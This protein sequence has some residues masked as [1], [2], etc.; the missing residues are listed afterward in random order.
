MKLSYKLFS[1]LF[2][3]SLCIPQV[4]AQEE[5]V[6]ANSQ[7]KTSNS[8]LKAY[9]SSVLLKLPFYEDFAQ[10][11]KIP[12]NLLWA[13]FDVYVNNSYAELPPS[14]GMASFDAINDFGEIYSNAG[15]FS[16]DADMLTSRPINLLEYQP[17]YLSSYIKGY[18]ETTSQYFL[19]NDIAYLKDGESFTSLK[20]LVFWYTSDMTLYIKVG[21]GFEIY[22]ADVF[23]QNNSLIEKGTETSAFYKDYSVDDEVNISFYYQAGGVFGSLGKNSNVPD[24]NDILQLE[25]SVPYDTTGVFINEITEG[26]IEIYNATDTI[27]DFS[28]Y[29]L[30]LNLHNLDTTFVLDLPSQISSY[31]YTIVDLGIADGQG[32]FSIIAYDQ[33]GNKI[34]SVFVDQVLSNGVSYA[35]IEDGSPDFTY[36]D[37]SFLAPNQD[38]KT[39]WTVGDER[40]EIFAF[41][42]VPINDADLLKK[43]FR[44]RFKNKVSVSPETDHARSEDIWNID[45]VSIT[46]KHISPYIPDVSIVDVERPTLNGFLNIPYKHL[47]ES[48]RKKFDSLT[49]TVHSFSDSER[50]FAVNAYRKENGV[51][52]DEYFGYQFIEQ[53]LV[54]PVNLTKTFSVDTLEVFDFFSK[55]VT[56]KDEASFD[57]GVFL[58]DKATLAHKEYRTN[59]TLVMKY[60]FKQHYAYD[61]GSS[62]AG[63][64]IKGTNY[65]RVAVRFEALKE[66]MLRGVYL[67]TNPTV[68]AITKFINIM[69]WEYDNGLPG[70]LIMSDNAVPIKNAPS[71]NEYTYYNFEPD[72]INPKYKDGVKLKGKYFIG[73]KQTKDFMLNIGVDLNTVIKQ[74]LYYSTTTEWN[75][76]EVEHPLMI[77]PVFGKELILD[78]DDAEVDTDFSV[79]PIPAS[80]HIYLDVDNENE[81]ETISLINILGRVVVQVPFETQ[82]DVSHLPAGVYTMQ[83]FSEDR[84]LSKQIIIQQ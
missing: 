84:I 4:Y 7:N 42:S 12:N 11:D 13:D 23:D 70:D 57:L 52:D 40:P 49:V 25:V 55:D 81:F 35:R 20:D 64:G 69:V 14:L 50:R 32:N 17:R 19:L 5:V 6:V 2:L 53:S 77:R 78:I 60:E 48:D 68:D 10:D 65:A 72:S 16:A 26:I 80:D 74:K 28:K 76:S 66:D 54:N 67:Y 15:V 39:I 27:V 29:S 41:V 46:S 58:T 63:Y 61:D 18:D 79:Y 71:Q 22:T 33:T 73:W 21:E 83:L 24:E 43:G 36:T 31:G 37:F 38:W 34:D 75:R 56:Q 45:E 47:P 62:E 3:S 44:F 9:I 1:L 82:I 8:E 51:A 30:L 59:D